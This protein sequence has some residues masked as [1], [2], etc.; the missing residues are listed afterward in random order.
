[1]WKR[2]K[3]GKMKE[4]Y[5][6]LFCGVKNNLGF[7]YTILR[8]TRLFEEIW[9]QICFIF[10]TNSQWCLNPAFNCFNLH[11]LKNTQ[12]NPRYTCFVIRAPSNLSTFPLRSPAW[13]AGHI[14]NSKSIW[15]AIKTHMLLPFEM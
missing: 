10:V 3:V 14:N 1:M 2:S 5:F 12:H 9:A 7:I 13:R 6:C 4:R 11:S 15:L 8:K